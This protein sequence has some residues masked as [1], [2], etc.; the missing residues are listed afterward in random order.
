MHRQRMFLLSNKHLIYYSGKMTVS[1]QDRLH[2]V[3]I[4]RTVIAMIYLPL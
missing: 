2:K 3:L 1:T 4:E